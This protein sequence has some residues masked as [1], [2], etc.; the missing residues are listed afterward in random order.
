M[1]AKLETIKKKIKQGNK[2]GF[3]RALAV[4]LVYVYLAKM[5]KKKKI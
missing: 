5:E 2:L 4:N 1:V 3:K